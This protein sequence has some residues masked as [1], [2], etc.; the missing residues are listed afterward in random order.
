MSLIPYD[1]S[2]NWVESILLDIYKL[3]NQ[4]L[5]QTVT[6]IVIIVSISQK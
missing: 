2:D 3:L 5:Y 1:G 4:I 6:K